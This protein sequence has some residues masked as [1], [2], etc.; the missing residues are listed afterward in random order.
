MLRADSED[1][2]LLGKCLRDTIGWYEDVI[3]ATDKEDEMDR[4]VR[5][6]R[7]EARTVDEEGRLEWEGGGPR[8]DSSRCR[9]VGT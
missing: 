9:F 8:Q 4:N 5:R 2:H 1:G 7:E 6:I 3:A